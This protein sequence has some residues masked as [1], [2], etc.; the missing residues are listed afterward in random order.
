MSRR[1]GMGVRETDGS[2]H[3]HATLN[4]RRVPALNEAGFKVV[5]DFHLLVGCGNVQHGA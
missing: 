5:W 2:L 1:L 4:T 3:E